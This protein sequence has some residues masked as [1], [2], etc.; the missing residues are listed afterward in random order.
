MCSP[1]SAVTM[2]DEHMWEFDGCSLKRGETFW[3]CLSLICVSVSVNII[4][5][6]D[7][8]YAIFFSRSFYFSE[9]WIV[10]KQRN[11]IGHVFLFA[12]ACVKWRIHLSLHMTNVN[13]GQ[14]K[15]IIWSSMV[16]GFRPCMHK[17]SRC[18]VFFFHFISKTFVALSMCCF[19]KKSLINHQSFVT[20]L[21]FYLRLI[22]TNKMTK[23]GNNCEKCLL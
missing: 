19:K 23:K 10:Q 13:N 7:K 6:F 1:T 8:V 2:A 17:R 9:M 4:W 16:N 14:S 21:L 12:F 22:E 11:T 20:E 18:H 15:R 3:L 5:I